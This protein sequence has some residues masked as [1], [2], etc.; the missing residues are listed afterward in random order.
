LGSLYYSADL[1]DMWL[2]DEKSTGLMFRGFYRNRHHSAQT[3][4]FSGNNDGPITD[5]LSS[6]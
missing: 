5:I 3:D 4:F 6:A 2:S 1:K